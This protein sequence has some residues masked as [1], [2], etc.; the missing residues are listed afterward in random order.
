MRPLTISLLAALG[1]GL[2]IAGWLA[3]HER[4]ERD[5]FVGLRG[6]ARINDF[7][8]A[9]LLIREL[10]FEA[11]SRAT[12]TP[13]EWMPDTAD[14]I[15]L[16]L[17]EAIAIGE[18]RLTMLNWIGAGGHL[19]LL[20]PSTRTDAI[21]TFLESFS[22]ELSELDPTI[23]VDDDGG[24]VELGEFENEYNIESAWTSVDIVLT[25]EE[26]DAEV[27]RNN[28]TIFA[29]RRPFNQGY[30]TLLADSLP[31]ENLA[32]ENG[33]NARL[34]ADIV[35]GELESGKV[36]ITFEATFAPLW[37][38]IWDAAPLLVVTIA[39]LFALWI[40]H[41]M[42]AFGPKEAGQIP[43]RRSIIEHIRASGV[44]TWRK[45][46]GGQL[47]ESSTQALVH[48]AAAKHPGLSNRS[49]E[50]QAKIIARI[51]GMSAQK[52]MDALH[53]HPDPKHREFTNSMQKL[54]SIRKEL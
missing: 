3:T 30:V 13:T 47:M 14:T 23:D 49:P 21:T 44:F 48:D 32:L 43:A 20:P 37:Q 15:V 6:E 4:V 52:I 54:Q 45:R 28:G 11:E 46:G 8:A 41:A 42:P 17:T 24:L 2:F 34:F 53:G 16:R 10:G 25:G 1:I 18:E 22:L 35:V 7:H 51:T 26:S 33:D 50:E 40:W 19:V 27:I 31:F 38:I 5:R 29:A 36:W 9:E 39:L 12:L